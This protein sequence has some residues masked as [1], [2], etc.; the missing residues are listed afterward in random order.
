MSEILAT[1]PRLEGEAPTVEGRLAD[2]IEQ[3]AEVWVGPGKD[4]Y[5][6]SDI[7]RAR[8]VAALRAVDRLVH[9]TSPLTDEEIAAAIETAANRVADEM[10][11]VLRTSWDRQ[12][13]IAKVKK[14][15]ASIRAMKGGG[16]R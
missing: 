9:Q 7:D 10:H 6:L 11:S 3:D 16:E 5:R 8:V 14:E 13:L 4:G 15:L 2:I 1:S 12:C